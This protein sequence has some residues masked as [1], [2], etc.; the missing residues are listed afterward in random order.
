V[1]N[2][3]G[4]VVIIILIALFSIVAYRWVY[5]RMHYAITDAVF[6][7]TDNLSNVSFK[8][9]AGKLIK[10][11]K[12]EGDKVKKGEILAEMDPTDYIVQLNKIKDEIKSLTLK[13]RALRA[14][15][16]RIKKEV[17]ININISKNLLDEIQVN[18]K[19]L[20]Y[21]LQEIDTNIKQLEKD[22]KRFENLTQK[23]LAPKRKLEVINTKL[24]TLNLKKQ[25]LLSKLKQL[26]IKHK[27]LKQKLSLAIAKKL[28]ITEIDNQIKSLKEK[29][30]ALNDAKKDIQNLISYTKLRAPFDG[31]IA[32][33]FK[34]LGEVVS[35]GIPV[36]SM[37][38]TNDVYIY[39]LLEETKLQGVKK[40][41][42]AIIHIDAYP[43]ET[44]EG[45]VD[46]INPATASKFALVPR[47]ITAGEFT[48]VV[49]R[50][51]I[52][53]RITRGKIELLK[54]GMGGEVEIEK[55]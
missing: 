5:H 23:G 51:P 1:K 40:G 14:K 41:N 27:I 36:Y 38:P 2:K 3:I 55:K 46:T 52:K 17:S 37:Y 44:F 53:I 6:V 7:E 34:S 30:K 8:R 20:H 54:V 10:L 49:Q 15:E 48:K 21:K 32:K 42:R 35:S 50:I 31:V 13:T 33:K 9:V 4:I 45:V 12:K 25:S 24:K 29:I 39:V 16:K 47:D 28:Q 22:Q 43:D 19:I 18:Q 11:N 26:K